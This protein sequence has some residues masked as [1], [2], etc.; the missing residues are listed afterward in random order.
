ML[1][2]PVAAF[3]VATLLA[4][5]VV[6]LPIALVVA[7]IVGGLEG[8]GIEPD[9]VAGGSG[10]FRGGEAIWRTFAWTAAIGTLAMAVGWAPGRRLAEGA[11]PWRVVAAV[12]PLLLP[13]WL[14][15][16]G[17]WQAIGPGTALGDLV[18]RH[19]L[20]GFARESALAIGLLASCWP[21][22]AWSVA[23]ERGGGD[24]G[25]TAALEAVD[26]LPWP[27]RLAI[28]FRE[29][30]AALL[31]GGVASMLL[32]WSTTVAFDLAGVRTFGFEL[33]TLDAEG[34]RPGTILLLGW[35]GLLPGLLLMLLVW[36]LPARREASLVEPVSRRRR[37]VFSAGLML[38]LV[39]VPLILLAWGLIRDP[40]VDGA[41]LRAFAILHGPSVPPT[42]AVAAAAGGLAALLA[43]ALA[44]AWEAR[45]RLVRWGLGLEAIA[46]TVAAGMPSAVL[47]AAVIELWN[48]P[49]VDWVHRSPAILVLGLFGR[50]GLVAPATAWWLSR[51][52]PLDERRLAAIDGPRRFGE[53]FRIERARIAAAMLG[54]FAAVFSL[55]LGEVA[56][57]SRLAPPGDAWLATAI[58]NAIHYQRGE[59]VL[60]A[61]FAMVLVGAIAAI[62][63]RWALRGGAT[64]RAAATR[65]ATIA[66]VGLLAIAPVGC[67]AED[68]APVG[69]A[70]DATSD[71]GP[72]P[73]PAAFMVGGQGTVPGRL[74]TPRAVD[75]APGEEAVLVVD[76]TGRL[77]KIALDG[78][79]RGRA[80]AVWP[81]PEFDMGFPTGITVVG[82]RI[83][84]ADTH[85]HRVLLLD[86]DGE[87][88]ET[89]GGYGTAPGEVVYPTDVV[90][91][92]DGRMFVGEYGGND[93]VQLFDADRRP[94]LAFDAS[95]TGIPFRRPQSLALASD[96]GELFIADACNHR[97]VVVDLEG[98]VLRVLGELG[99]EPG[100]LAYPY[101]IAFDGRG[102]LLVTEFGNNR[103][104]RL[105][106]E[107]GASLGCWGGFG[108][109]EGRLRYP[110]SVAVRNGRVAVLDSGNHR[111]VLL[112]VDDLLDV[113]TP[114]VVSAGT[115]VSAP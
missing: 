29:D 87:V 17:F 52:R 14:L 114:A 60:I 103:L 89:F 84:V 15:F 35:P 98:R 39:G 4:V 67:G 79:Q 10:S 97:I 93:R 54:T 30:R 24:A 81:L 68:A 16:H 2:A 95:E 46:W 6:L 62:V 99:R 110:W 106:P 23:I 56:L 40:G 77:Q 57:S 20:V 66:I 70:A 41:S 55:S 36:S 34:A 59:T 78:S 96:G 76:R 31:R 32:L 86:A 85:E 71:D 63:L 47:A 115:E 21:L 12:L 108:E 72:P 50:F 65:I 27:R 48:R 107:T 102:G 69:R 42:L 13:G 28:A 90:E 26:G 45:S 9:A 91:L 3:A 112:E 82:E 38:L 19:E 104:Q 11:A 61:A 94:V 105:D 83:V 74:R 33:R 7:A 73:L 49:G 92:P 58:L 100:R 101:G 113:A 64:S 18:A 25:A 44:M 8:V 37:D 111:I 88:L 53:M 22:V 80:V 1:P 109:D 5:P 75:F 51:R 43:G